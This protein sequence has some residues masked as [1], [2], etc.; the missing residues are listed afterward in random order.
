MTPM[1][2]RMMAGRRGA[3]SAYATLK[4]A[5]LTAAANNSA[6]LWFLG[7]AADLTGNVFTDS[8]GTI[9]AGAGSQVGYL[10]DRNANAFPQ[11]QTTGILQPTIVL[12]G[13][14]YYVLALSGTQLLT[15]GRVFTQ[16]QNS[17]VIGVAGAFDSSASRTLFGVGDNTSNY[18]SYPQLT[19]STGAI[20]AAR[21]TSDG[22][23]NT[24]SGTSVS[25]SLPPPISTVKTGTAI[26]LW[27][28]G[29][30]TTTGATPTGVNVMTSG[31]IGAFPAQ[32]A[33]MNGQIALVCA[34]PVAMSISDRSA[35]EAFGA[36]LT[37]TAYP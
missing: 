21:Y 34:A 24:I 7:N 36:L 1:Q 23:D 3:T 5:A 22:G 13:A 30:S 9:Q 17:T 6:S 8:A 26:V 11:T 28:K 18:N 4:T 25:N 29:V 27:V 19:F 15:S 10:K 31:N 35:I 32:N 14:G 2:W 33:P 20:P 37:G 16:A 12:N